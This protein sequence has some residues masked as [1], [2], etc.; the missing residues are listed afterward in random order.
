VYDADLK[1]YFDS[2][3]H[4][5]LLA[6][7]R[8]RVVDRSVLQLIRMWLEAL[9]VEEKEGQ[10]GG[11]QWSRVKQGT[12]QGGV[13]SPLLANLYLHWFDALFHGPQGP[14]Q[15]A[16]VKLVRYADDFVALAKQMGAETIEFIGRDWKA[17]TSWRSTGKRREWWICGR[18]GQV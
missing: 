3:P 4:S 8:A 5:Q 9:V 15:K 7:L 18:K 16:G 11:R 17:S 6:C 14:A 2:I 13:V 1:G 12:P 10:G